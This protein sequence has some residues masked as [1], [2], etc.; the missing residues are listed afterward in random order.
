MCNGGLSRAET[1]C[2][3]FFFSKADYH[4]DIPD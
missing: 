1:G 3:A 4:E 2:P